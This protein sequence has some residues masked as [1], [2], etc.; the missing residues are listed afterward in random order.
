MVGY[1]H[2][3]LSRQIFR[4]G[5]RFK[6]SRT[7]VRNIWHRICMEGTTEP[8][9]HGGGKNSNFTQGVLQLIESI[10]RARRAVVC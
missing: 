10:K 4:F 3:L 1:Q 8:W 7:T 2:W 5:E 9:Q 6:V